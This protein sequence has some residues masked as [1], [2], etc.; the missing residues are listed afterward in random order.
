MEITGTVESIRFQSEETGFCV[1]TLSDDKNKETT[2][3]GTVPGIYTGMRLRL[4][5][6][7]V[8]DP[9][10]GNQLKVKDF[11]EILPE[12]KEGIEKYLSS[13][14]IKGI[15]P[16]TAKNIVKKFG[17]DTFK[18]LDEDMERL[19]EVEGIGKKK[20]A[21]IGEGY[22][23]TRELR[24]IMVFLQP[25]GISPRQCLKIH[26]KY[27]SESLQKIRENPYRLTYD[28]RSFGFKRADELAEK[29]GIAGDSRERFGAGLMYI[30]SGKSSSGHTM[31]PYDTVKK[32]TI[33]LLGINEE[34]FDVYIQYTQAEDPNIVIENFLGEFY[35]S[36]KKI[37]EAEK[38]VA[39]RILEI[40]SEE[41]RKLTVNPSVL[42]EQYEK[43]NGITLHENQ[44]EAV[45][46]AARNNFLIITG[47]PGTGKT[48]I[49]KCIL[50]ILKK[51]GE[52][53]GLAAPTGRAAKRMKEATGMN[54]STIHRLLSLGVSE[55]EQDEFSSEGE[56]TELKFD[57][58][59]IDEASMIDVILMNSLLKSVKPGTRVI[60][61]GDSDQLPSV[62]PGRVLGDL[63]DSG[64]TKVI[65]LSRIYRQGNESMITT[66]AHRINSGEEPI[67]NGKGSDFFFIPHENQETGIELLMDLISRR[68]P[69]WNSGWDPI[70]DIQVLSPMRKRAMGTEEI[71]ESLRKV[72]NP[73][74]KENEKGFSG[75]FPGDKVMQIRNNYNLK[76]R[77][78]LVKTSSTTEDEAGAFNGDIGY[79]AA[80]DEEEKILT[81]LYE[82]ERYV[83]YTPAELDDIEPAY[84]VTI[85]KSQGSEFPVVVIPVYFSAP[86]LMTRNLIY[87]GVTRGR[88]LVVLI[89]QKRAL[90]Y[91]VRNIN[92]QERFTSLALR[93][94][95]IMEFFGSETYE[96]P[97]FTEETDFSEESDFPDDFEG[98]TP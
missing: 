18:I 26:N 89:G 78:T 44:K 95:N 94:K 46:E 30:L 81:V 3:V 29:L 69:S 82:D 67:V 77:N 51:S 12:S 55:D 76:G 42:I 68:L 56:E 24:N 61:V 1:A 32:E 21:V 49:I 13:G 5:G 53:V 66:N 92:T 7:T 25:L 39:G 83:D 35:V 88:K 11:E 98:D 19:R 31:V 58:I 59:I 80:V 10:W 16:L 73:S 15:G 97:D 93:L 60:L 65:K 23:E 14:I 72:L 22:A 64:C 63:I 2:F 87:T 71:N 70:R 43:L 75:Y 85:H 8:T 38:N 41:P 37:S 33:E 74:F 28:I 48:T 54:A 79:V 57:T 9:R 50:D 34:L 96:K 62:G 90:D 6:E 27:G 47:G 17:A 36:L 84:A 45:L 4:T 91:M 86:S 20:L 40:T 52:K